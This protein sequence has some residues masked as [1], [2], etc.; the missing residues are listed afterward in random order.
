MDAS[1]KGS[2][3]GIGNDG[4]FRVQLKTKGDPKAAPDEQ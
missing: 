3:T 1:G 4:R 2:E